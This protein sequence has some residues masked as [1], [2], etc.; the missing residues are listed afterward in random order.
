M[1]QLASRLAPL[2]VAAGLAAACGS[3]GAVPLNDSSSNPQAF[4][5]IQGHVMRAPGQDPRAGGA[6]A[7]PTVPVPGDPIEIRNAAGALVATAVSGKDGSFQVS[8][9]AGTY[10]LVES[11]CAVKQQ[12][13]VR[14]QSTTEVKLTVPNSC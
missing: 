13:E 3:A 9:D 10:T 1:I 2:A 7:S 6:S 5:Q 8:V 12:V 4:G 14:A 11:I